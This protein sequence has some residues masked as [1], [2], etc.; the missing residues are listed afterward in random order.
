LAQ[1]VLETEIEEIHADLGKIRCAY[2]SGGVVVE[3]FHGNVKRLENAF[4][5]WQR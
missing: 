5:M 1:G 3:E 4:Q 2:Q